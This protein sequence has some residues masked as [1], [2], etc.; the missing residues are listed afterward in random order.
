[1]ADDPVD[2]SF[3]LTVYV[4]GFTAPAW[5][6]DAVVYQIFPDRFD[7]GEKKNDPKTGDPRYDDP[8][9]ALPW[10]TLPEGFCRNYADAATNCPWR[11]DTTP[12]ASSPTKEQPRDR[13]YMGGDLKGVAQ[14]LEYL[15][16]LGI[17]TIYLNPVFDAGSNHSYDTQDYTKIDPAF[18]T[19]KDWDHLVKEAKK[20]GIRVILDGVFNHMSSDSPFFDRYHRYP[21][22][23][24]CESLASPWR[25]WFEFTTSNVPCDG[26]RTTTAGS[27]STRIPVLKKANPA[28]QQYF[29]T[30]PDAISRRWLKDGA[31]GWRLDVSGDPSFPSGYW[32]TFRSVVKGVDPDAL[33][34][35]ETWQKDTH[36]APDAARR[37]ARHDDELPAPRRRPRPAHAGAVRLEG[38]RRQRAQSSPRASSPTGSRRSARTTP[39]RRTSR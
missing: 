39:T 11:F 16:K 14:K 4:P 13:D 22:V 33:T 29:L 35:S 37:P 12:P 36:P 1:M 26:R 20:K 19:Q 28:V 23:G 32:E 17:T 15:K 25:N 24:A 7:N 10:E 30:G 6:K 9:L 34:I 2:N 5:A 38:L 21:T 3:A 31:A 27:A 18:G 8:V